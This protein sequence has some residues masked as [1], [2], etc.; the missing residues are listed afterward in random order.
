[1]NETLRNPEPGCVRGTG[2]RCGASQPLPR[3]MST[4][5]LMNPPAVAGG[6]NP[7]RIT[8]RRRT[9]RKPLNDAARQRAYR[10]ALRAAEM[11]S[12]EAA[13]PSPST[14][15]ERTTVREAARVTAG[16]PRPAED[17]AEGALFCLVLFATVA[18]LVFG[19]ADSVDFGARWH[20]F[21][22]LVQ[23]LVG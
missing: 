2:C 3:T 16:L 17:G 1:M 20:D 18:A 9:E 21:M 8:G 15:P 19:A 10:R 5:I 11:A 13:M 4:T 6:R 7:L 12:W 14:L 22:A 23:R